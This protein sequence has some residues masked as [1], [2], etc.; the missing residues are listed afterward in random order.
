[1]SERTGKQVVVS[2]RCLQVRGSRAG[3]TGVQCPTSNTLELPMV[4]TDACMARHVPVVALTVQQLRRKT[5]ASL[6][7]LHV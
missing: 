2:L 1:M 5:R 4:G 7:G 3:H 6:T